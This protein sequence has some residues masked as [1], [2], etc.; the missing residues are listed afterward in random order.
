LDF[1]EPTTY[2]E[3]VSHHWWQEAMTKEL[4]VLQ[5]T[6]T[7]RIISFPPGKKPIACKW[8][9]KVTCKADGSIERLKARLVVKGFT[10][11][12]G[13]DYTETF[14]PVVKITTIRVLMTIAVKKAG[15]Y[16]NLM[17]IMPSFMGISMRKF[18][19]NYLLVFFLTFQGQYANYKSPFMGSNKLHGNGMK[20]SAQFFLKGVTYILK[21][22]IIFSIRR[23]RI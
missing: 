22:I 21:M 20:N 14:S 23:N 10:Q 5:N 19:C 18:T 17:S 13:I 12:E 7:L 15:Y 6:N 1:S 9:C 11:K 2:E 16:T 8:V 4:Q 3:D